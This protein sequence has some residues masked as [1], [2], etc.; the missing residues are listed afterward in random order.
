M[1]RLYWEVMWIASERDGWVR[2]IVQDGDYLITLTPSIGDLLVGLRKPLRVVWGRI[3]V[4]YVIDIMTL[5][6]NM[7]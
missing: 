3:T 7:Y 5:L 2:G 4:W 6:S 1:F